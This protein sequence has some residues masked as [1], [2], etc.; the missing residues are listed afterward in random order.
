MKK[1]VA[2]SVLAFTFAF[3][4]PSFAGVVKASAKAGKFAAKESAER[5][6]KQASF[7]LRH[8]VKSAHAIVKAIF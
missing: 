1:F 8:P 4:L 7:P 2:I 3:T 5:A 6:L